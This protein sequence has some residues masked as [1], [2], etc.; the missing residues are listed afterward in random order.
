[1]KEYFWSLLSANSRHSPP[2][3]PHLTVLPTPV[4]LLFLSAAI[5]EFYIRFL[6]S[7]SI[8]CPVRP[9]KPPTLP[10][11]TNIWHFCLHPKYLPFGSSENFY[12]HFAPSRKLYQ[13]TV[14]AATTCKVVS[15][16]SPV[17]WPCRKLH[18]STDRSRD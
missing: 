7:G 14:S 9:T 4:V 1:M 8:P 6:S 12:F 17:H 18:K 10:S 13:K 16:D 2:P 11:P 15:V 3:V 5:K